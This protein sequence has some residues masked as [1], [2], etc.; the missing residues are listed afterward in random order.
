MANRRIVAAPVV[1]VLVLGLLSVGRPV[2][3]DL[4]AAEWKATLEK[5]DVAVKAQDAGKAAAGLREAAKD[6]SERAA[7]LAVLVL[8]KLPDAPEVYAAVEEAAITF[9]KDKA[10][11]TLRKEALAQ[12]DWTVR[13][14]LVDA[15]AA[16]GARETDTIAKAT[17]D[18]EEKVQV[19]AI[20][21]LASFKTIAATEAIIACMEKVD[22]KGPQAR[23]VV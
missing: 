14:Q 22:E 7:K 11:E 23:G 19:A 18:K 13:V 17:K 1:L 8:A 5:I 4:S 2:A 15:L 9:T 16:R 12:K 10:L 20:R 21:A 3:A 6:D